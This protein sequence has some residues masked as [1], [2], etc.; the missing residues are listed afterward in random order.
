MQEGRAD[1]RRVDEHDSLIE[2]VRTD[3]DRDALDCEPIV[4]VLRLRNITFENVR[5][6]G[7]DSDYGR[8]FDA[9]E[10]DPRAVSICR[11]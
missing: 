2:E 4:W 6:F 8:L 3:L 5:D 7:R 10:R 11:R 9:Q 1:A